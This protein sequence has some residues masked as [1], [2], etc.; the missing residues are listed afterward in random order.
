MVPVAENGE[1]TSVIVN[2]RVP[3]SFDKLFDT[4]KRP[5]FAAAF[6]STIGTYWL[7]DRPVIVMRSTTVVE[8]GVTV[9]EKVY[10]LPLVPEPVTVVDDVVFA[11]SAGLPE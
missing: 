9:T 1:S 10:G 5:P 2:T 8:L 6:K 3:E 7:G 11:G 4:R